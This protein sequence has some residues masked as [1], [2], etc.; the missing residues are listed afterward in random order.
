MDV[1]DVFELGL[2]KGLVNYCEGAGLD[3]LDGG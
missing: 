2:V 3:A 1:F